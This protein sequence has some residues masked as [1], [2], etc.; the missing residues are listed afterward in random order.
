MTTRKGSSLHPKQTTDTEPEEE[1]PPELVITGSPSQ[2][3]PT[4][5]VTQPKPTTSAVSLSNPNMDKPQSSKQSGHSE[6]LPQIQTLSLSNITQFL[7]C[8]GD[9]VLKWSTWKRLFTD[10]LIANGLDTVPEQ[11]KLAILRSSLGTEGYRICSE[12]CPPNLDFQQTLDSLDQRF[13]PPASTIFNRHQFNSRFQ[14]TGE[15]SLQFVTTLRALAHKCEYPQNICEELVRDRFV[16]GTNNRE[17][18]E[19]LLLEDDTLTLSAALHIAQTIERAASESTTFAATVQQN[20]TDALHALRGTPHRRK[21]FRHFQR[22]QSREHRHESPKA[23]RNA[24]PSPHR[25]FSPASSN[26]SAGRSPHNHYRRSGYCYCCGDPSHKAGPNCPA[27]SSTCSNCNKVGHYA[28]MCHSSRRSSKSPNRNYNPYKKTNFHP[29]VNALES[30]SGKRI[31]YFFKISDR[32]VSL[33]AD[34]GADASILNKDTVQLLKPL[35]ELYHSPLDIKD[36]NGHSVTVLGAVKVQVRFRNSPPRPHEFIVVEQG[37]NIMGLDLFKAF[38]FHVC[39]PS[40]SISSLSSSLPLRNPILRQYPNLLKSDPNKTLKDF[41]HLPDLDYTVPPKV[42]A[43]RRLPLAL[44]DKV[45][46]ELHRLEKENVLEKI[47]SSPWVSNMVV[48]SKA[49]GAVRICCD[50]SDVNKA[51]I[52]DKFPLPTNEELS[53]FFSG[54]KFFSKLDLKWGYLQ[55]ELD[56]S[57]RYITAMIT[58]IGLFQ[59]KRLPFGLCSAPSCF[60]KTISMILENCPGTKHL[61]DDIIVCGQT[62]AEHDANLN[63]VLKHLDEYGVT[64]NL[65]K[66]SIGVQKVDFVGHEVSADGVRPLQSNVKTLLEI[67]EPKTEKQ[68]RSFLGAAGYYMKFL[69]NYSD[70][71]DPLRELLKV[72]ARWCWSS[73][74]QIAFDTLKQQISSAPV[75]AHF[76]PNAPTL[77][78]TD[79]SAVALGAVLS[80]IQNGVELPVAFASRRLTPAERSYSASELEALACIW[81]CEHWHYYLYGRPFTLVT[82]HAPLTV[83]LSGGTS[84]R[85][86]MR[87][88]RWADRLFQYNFKVKYRPGKENT[89]ADLLSRYPPIKTDTEQPQENETDAIVSTIFGSPTLKT[90]SLKQLGDATKTDE[91]LSIVTEFITSGFPKQ[92]PN[93]PELRAFHEVQ[94]ELS[95]GPNSVIFR[96]EQAVIPKSLREQ[97]LKLAHE[98]HFGITRTKALCR[99][100]VWWPGMCSDVERLVHNC[101]A[102]AVTDRGRKPYPTPPLKPVPSPSTP[103]H[104]LALDIHGPMLEAPENSKYLLVLIDLHSKWPIVRPT[105]Y[106]TTTAVTNFL[107]DCFTDLGLPQQIIT[108][109]GRQFVSREFEDFLSSLQIKHCRTSLYHPQA[110]GAVER[111]NRVLVQGLRTALVEGRSFQVALRSILVS[112]RSTPHAATAVSPAE[113][114]LGRKLLLP[115]SLL[116]LS[117]STRR[118]IFSESPQVYRYQKEYKEYTDTVRHAHPSGLNTGDAVRVR[119]QVRHSKL[120][121]TW[122]HPHRVVELPSAD[123]A[124]LEDGTVWNAS[125]LKPVGD[126]RGSLRGSESRE[127]PARSPL[128]RSTRDRHPPAR[129]ADYTTDY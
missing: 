4:L 128:R 71:I 108:D 20:S 41:V 17:L 21:P 82:D 76:N 67:P 10:H 69:P 80:Q 106:I 98:S 1:T 120:E 36:Y 8:P 5:R 83:L 114:H 51:I 42:Q 60:Q 127:E 123:T 87:L 94:T 115:L 79:A 65:Q 88:L 110:N 28:K 64:L 9:P 16:A 93:D 35:P 104:T 45:I 39:E 43:L 54:A 52:P 6:P 66:C 112:Y 7:P 23:F 46:K 86:S 73:E 121:P 95:I 91:T 89:V 12:M 47:N 40:T 118:V 62:R 26:D 24:S 97:V 96:A 100:A 122:S 117:P 14:Q 2:P 102:C 55:M 85:K 116:S 81:S 58:P 105:H 50:L 22:H 129:F 15:N 92:R 72:D 126:H 49:D 99:E 119:R 37:S 34:S 3:L 124:R 103:W 48:V 29:R 11:R 84:G 75:L 109:N 101:E 68:L 125:Q 19:R 74:C 44:R 61:I 77:V 56:E 27:R 111:F 38:G 59:W 30:N 78:S 53:E 63:K 32:I 90:I 33:Q 57:I 13:S 18:R 25:S 70:L 107:S 113:L 31:T